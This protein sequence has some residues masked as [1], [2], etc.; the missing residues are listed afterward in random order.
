[1]SRGHSPKPVTRMVVWGRA[2]GRC[3]YPNCGKQ[4]DGDLIT[5]DLRKNHALLAHIVAS[6]PKGPRGDQVLSLQLSDDPD[7][8]MLMCAVHHDEI[9]DRNKLDIY[10]V[11]TL[12]D[13]KRRHEERIARALEFPHAPRAHILR[14]SAAIGDNETAIPRQDCA[15]AMIPQFVI[16][17]R[18]PIDISIRGLEHKDSDR[19]YYDTELTNLH[20]V[21][22][23]EIRGRF[24]DGEL[25]HLAVFG[26]API[27]LLMELGRLL[28][29][30]S[31][32][33][34]FGRHRGPH[35]SWVWPNDSPDISFERRKGN[36]AHKQVALK[37][38]VS[39][40]IPDSRVT[41]V[42]GEDVSIWEIRSSEFGT[43][44]LRSQSV[45]SDYRKLAGRVFDEIKTE[46]GPD[47]CVSVFPA[48]PT[49]CA[50]E[51]GRVWQPKAHPPFNVYDETP[52]G[53]IR[54][55][56]IE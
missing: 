5:G 37:L 28:S 25:E 24:R 18:N 56:R 22:D 1:M 16:A 15:R 54:R 42:L 3:S 34:V 6:D 45:L 35:P 12:L 33:T 50:I 41:S 21:Y 51:F 48:V 53:F 17:D 26:F 2:A 14:I 55:H 23:R 4:L 10:T 11:E 31:D 38:A 52:S 27:P 46:H 13:M 32:V 19:N 7:N 36:S 20:R 40:E 44:V 9:D 43:S 29:D 30:L 8:L 49:T 47:A 39:A